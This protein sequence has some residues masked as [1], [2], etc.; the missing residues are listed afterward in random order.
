MEESEQEM[1]CPGCLVA[2]EPSADFCVHCGRPLSSLATID[3][4]YR[5]YTW[6]WIYRKCASQPVRL[7]VLIVLWLGL[8]PTLAVLFRRVTSPGSVPLAD[9]IDVGWAALLCAVYGMV[10]YKITRTFILK[11]R[12]PGDRDDPT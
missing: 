9:Y 5:A 1:L 3:P 7:F 4:V 12:E 10:L 11:R 8:L 2:N 6:G